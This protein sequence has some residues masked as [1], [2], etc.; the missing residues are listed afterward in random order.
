M[1]RGIEIIQ[2]ILPVLIVLLIGVIIRRIRLID[3]N[4]INALKKIVVNIALPAVLLSAFATT[5]YSVRD[6]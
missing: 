5:A 4:G 3:R 6:I 2:T 1:G